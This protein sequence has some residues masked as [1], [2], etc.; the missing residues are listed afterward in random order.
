MLAGDTLR[1]G[2]L[3]ALAILNFWLI[4]SNGVTVIVSLTFDSG[5]SCSVLRYCRVV[6]ACA[7][8][9]SSRKLVTV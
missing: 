3:Y 4:L 8:H 5:I 1:Y 9:G 2:V 6:D 7:S